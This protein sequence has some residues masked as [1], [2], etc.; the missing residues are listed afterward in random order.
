MT[1]D[2]VMAVFALAVLAGYLGIVMVRVG[3]IDLT[4]AI[5]IGLALVANASVAPTQATPPL[6]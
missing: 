4:V 6:I 1:L 3:R 5:G 2:R